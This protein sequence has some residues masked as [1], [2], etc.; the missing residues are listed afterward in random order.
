MEVYP[1][2]NNRL[3]APIRHGVDHWVVSGVRKSV[4][5]V[6]MQR[7]RCNRSRTAGCGWVWCWELAVRPEQDFVGFN[8][9]NTG[10]LRT[11]VP[12][13]VMTGASVSE[14]FQER[15]CLP[16][17]SVVSGD[18]GRSGRLWIGGRSLVAFGSFKA[19]VRYQG[20]SRL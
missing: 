7:R 20:R 18:P 15:V 13:P 2:A 9:P 17:L 11:C 8:C 4:E 5:A 12:E 19:L 14:R 3:T 1:G 6:T 10:R 16:S